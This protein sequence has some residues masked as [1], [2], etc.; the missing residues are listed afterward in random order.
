VRPLPLPCGP[1]ESTDLDS[2]LFVLTTLVSGYTLQFWKFHGN[3]PGYDNRQIRGGESS[4][5][6][7]KAA[8]SMAPHD[9]EAYE[10]VNMEDN[11]AYAGERYGHVNPYNSDDYDDPNRYGALPPRTANAGMFDAD[12]EY[13]SSGG[14]GPAP[15]S[16]IGA[17]GPGPSS[18]APGPYDDAAQFP[19]GNYDRI[20]R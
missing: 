8:F 12:T 19:A 17:A 11:E 7:D 6:P 5:D 1:S 4:I 10:R 20:Q 13:T 16:S 2:I 18:Y 15:A 3:L 14:A 9:D